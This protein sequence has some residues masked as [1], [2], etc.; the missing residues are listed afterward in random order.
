ME[1]KIVRTNGF[2]CPVCSGFINSSIEDLLG[3]KET[4]CPHCGLKI[5]ITF[6]KSDKVSEILEKMKN[7]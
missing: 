6:E 2:P 3:E 5:N 1:K 7:H 4:I